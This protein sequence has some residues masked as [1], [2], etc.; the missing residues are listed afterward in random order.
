MIDA[1]SVIARPPRRFRS[2][3][4]YKDS[5]LPWLGENSDALGS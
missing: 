1:P 3:Q 4:A 5:D 2:Y